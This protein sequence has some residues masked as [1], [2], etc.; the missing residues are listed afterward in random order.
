MSVSFVKD[1]NTRREIERS[2][3]DVELYE[4]RAFGNGIYECHDFTPGLTAGPEGPGGNYDP[5][6]TRTFYDISVPAEG[7]DNDISGNLFKKA[8]LLDPCSSFPVFSLYKFSGMEHLGDGSKYEIREVTK[9]WAGAALF[10][11]DAFFNVSE[12][13]RELC[14]KVMYK[15]QDAT[16]SKNWSAMLQNGLNDQI[17]NDSIFETPKRSEPARFSISGGKI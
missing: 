6:F 14:A 8:S 13:D 10:A 11:C 15:A 17:F 3:Q 9:P 7:D 1:S 16:F 5:L 2:V 12:E 4:K